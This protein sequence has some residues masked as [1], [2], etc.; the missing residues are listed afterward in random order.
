MPPALSNTWTIRPLRA[1]DFRTGKERPPVLQEAEAQLTNARLNRSEG[2]VRA[3]TA[4]HQA[5][6]L[7]SAQLGARTAAAANDTRS[8]P[9]KVNELTAATAAVTNAASGVTSAQAAVTIA[10]HNLAKTELAGP[11]S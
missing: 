7:T 5:A 11:R 10:E 3:D 1:I 2:A 9:P 4:L 6:A 8:A